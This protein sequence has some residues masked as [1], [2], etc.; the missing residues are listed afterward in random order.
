[1]GLALGANL[2]FYTSMTKGLKLTVRKFLGLI[3]TFVEVTGEKLFAPSWIGLSNIAL[4]MKTI[5]LRI[6]LMT[7]I[8]ILWTTEILENTSD[9][10]KKL[11]AWLANNQMKPKDY[12][13]H[14][15]LS[16]PEDGAAI[17]IEKSIM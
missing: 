16:F 17:Q 10:T 2:K 9:L 4:K 1:M 8:Y 12:K 3:L 14:M 13:C 15:I 11:F 5:I 7:L 6:M